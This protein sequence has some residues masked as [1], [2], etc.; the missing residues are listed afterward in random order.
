MLDGLLLGAIYLVLAVAPSALTA[1]C[2]KNMLGAVGLTA[3]ILIA[4]PI[5]AMVHAITNWL[6]SALVNAPVS[7]LAGRGFA[8]Y[9]PAAG[10]ALAASALLLFCAVVRLGAR[11]V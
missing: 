11:E 9:L 4:L 10:I 6:P 8:H 1:S 3:V 7:L 2:V 5:T